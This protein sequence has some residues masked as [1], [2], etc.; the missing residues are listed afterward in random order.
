VGGGLGGE[1]LAERVENRPCKVRANE[2]LEPSGRG[3]GH[4][5]SPRDTARAATRRD[6]ERCTV[7]R[8][9]LA[10]VPIRTDLV[11]ELART[12]D[13]PDL[14]TKLQDA[15][16]RDVKIIALDFGE[17]DRILEALADD[18]PDGL[19]ELRGVLLNELEWRRRERPG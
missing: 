5:S 2:R 14:A 3:H 6:A 1:L 17:R 19:A 4:L 12:V 15:V 13:D 18:C 9:F 8:V 16:V 11:R 7:E 10:G